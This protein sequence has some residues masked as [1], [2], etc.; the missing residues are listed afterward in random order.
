MEKEIK[1]IN[2]ITADGEPILED[3]NDEAE[4]Y[5]TSVTVDEDGLF[6]S[7]VEISGVKK[8]EEDLENPYQ[9]A[10]YTNRREYLLSLA[11]EYGVDKSVVFDLASVLGKDEDFDALISELEDYADSNSDFEYDDA[12]DAEVV[13]DGVEGTAGN[14]LC[15]CY[16]DGAYEKE[17]SSTWFFK[18]QQ[19]IQY[20]FDKIKLDYYVTVTNTVDNTIMYFT[21]EKYNEDVYKTSDLIDN[22]PPRSN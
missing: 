11:D 7:E 21:P 20:I 8:V 22:N 13:F 14:Y 2:P 12:D 4:T 1:I 17:V 18:V 10:G 3:I 6:D 19:V 15:T 5:F 16:L 9:E